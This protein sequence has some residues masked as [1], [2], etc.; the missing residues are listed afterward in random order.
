MEKPLPA[1][2]SSIQLRRMVRSVVLVALGRIANIVD[3]VAIEI[4]LSSERTEDPGQGA[5]I[6]TTEVRLEV[7]IS[8]GIGAAFA[9]LQGPLLLGGIEL[10]EVADASAGLRFLAGIDEVGNRDRGQQ[11]DDG[12]NDHDFHQGESA[13]RPAGQAAFRRN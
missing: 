10:A 2:N 3:G 8:G 6:A 9:L 4:A 13:L 5:G 1:L 11:T 7:G 12:D